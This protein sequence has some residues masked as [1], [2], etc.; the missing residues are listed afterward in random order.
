MGCRD[1]VVSRQPEASND[2]GASVR[3]Q[4]KSS[5]GQPAGL[6]WANNLQPETLDESW[7]EGWFACQEEPRLGAVTSKESAN[8]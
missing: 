2:E 6:R 8:R 4:L 7:R 3:G 5:M 1:S